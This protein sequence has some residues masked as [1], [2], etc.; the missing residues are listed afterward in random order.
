MHS[1]LHVYGPLLT[2]W[3]H[4]LVLSLYSVV[5][6]HHSSWGNRT[7]WGNKK[8][9]K[10]RKSK[11]T[12]RNIWGEEKSIQAQPNVFWKTNF[13]LA[14]VDKPLLNFLFVCVNNPCYKKN[15]KRPQ[16]IM[17]VKVKKLTLK[18][19]FFREHCD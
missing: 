10:K 8:K 6:P 13:S 17:Q 15:L 16:E 3:S 5:A 9:L 12:L 1:S 7:L 2:L 4:V 19:S 14:S 11:A 18:Q